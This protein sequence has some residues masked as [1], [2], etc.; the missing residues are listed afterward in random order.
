MNLQ[1]N[2]A[3]LQ[4]NAIFPRKIRY[5]YNVSSTKHYTDNFAAVRII[6]ETVSSLFMITSHSLF[7]CRGNAEGEDDDERGDDEREDEEG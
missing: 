4:K 3:V 2:L 6:Q 7:F 1:K 5:Q